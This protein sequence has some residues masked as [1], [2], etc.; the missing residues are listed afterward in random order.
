MSAHESLEQACKVALAAADDIFSTPGRHAR[1]RQVLALRD[2]IES[3]I[4]A[5][6]GDGPGLRSIERL[7]EDLGIDAAHQVLAHPA[8]RAEA[9][10]HVVVG[11][12][13]EGLYGGGKAT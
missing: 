11:Q 8:P 6:A 9:S 5:L 1:Q 13:G 2:A 3:V 12:H 7:L 4:V 10:E